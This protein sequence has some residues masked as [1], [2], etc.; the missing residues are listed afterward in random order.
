MRIILQLFT[1]GYMLGSYH[2]EN[3]FVRLIGK[4]YGVFRKKGSF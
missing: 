3:I 1:E 4:I 2:T